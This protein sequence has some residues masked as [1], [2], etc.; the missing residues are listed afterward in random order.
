MINTDEIDAIARYALSLEPSQN[1]TFVDKAWGHVYELSCKSVT[2][3]AAIK[4]YDPKVYKN[5]VKYYYIDELRFQQVLHDAIAVLDI[6]KKFRSQKPTKKLMQNYIACL[7]SYDSSMSAFRK[8]I[9]R[10]QI[11]ID[12]DK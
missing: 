4:D 1:D 2:D 5:Y 12:Y 11:K 7:N 10:S 8:Q 9:E 6:E 3:S